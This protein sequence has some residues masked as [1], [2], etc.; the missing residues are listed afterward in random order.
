M[1]PIVQI[2]LAY[3]LILFIIAVS[4][5]ENLGQEKEVFFT[6]LRCSFQ[7][8]LLG[9]T[10]KFVFSLKNWYWLI[11]LL[12]IMTGAAAFIGAE[13]LKIK[14]SKLYALK[15]CFLSLF[16]STALVFVP[17]L[18]IG[19]IHNTLREVLTLWG[20]VLGNSVSSLSLAYDRLVA[21][22]FNRKDEVEAKVALGATLKQALKECIKPAVEA[23]LIP[24]Y[25]SLK[26]AGI[27]F[28]PGITAGMIIAGADPLTAVVYQILVMYMIL[29]TSFF[30]AYLLV[31]FTCEKAF[32]SCIYLQNKK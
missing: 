26:S 30:T 7:L 6:S 3:I 5:K 2:L 18:L 13:R 29:A 12:S 8:L 19:A 32:A 21:E 11:L 1:N 16:I 10:L 28:I 9:F 27:V 24:K 25:N 4:Q 23:S 14:A 22:S 17:L 15:V 20:L 31:L